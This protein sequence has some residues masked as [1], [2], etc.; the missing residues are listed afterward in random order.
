MDNE[1]EKYIKHFHKY[2]NKYYQS[3][4]E[5]L[6]NDLRVSSYR[7]HNEF[8][9]TISNTAGHRLSTVICEYYDVTHSFGSA[10]LEAFKGVQKVISDLIYKTLIDKEYGE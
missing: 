1:C 7:D 9:I 4:K 10:E 6:A 2:V 5:H 8:K 3:I